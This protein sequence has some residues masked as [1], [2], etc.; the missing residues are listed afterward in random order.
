MSVHYAVQAQVIDLL[1]DTPAA[2]EAF[3]VDTNVWLWTTYA[4]ATQR[5]SP[6]RRQQLTAC[7]GYLQRCQRIG[8]QLHWC[9]L[10]LSE[11]AHQIESAER[12]VWNATER[13]ARRAECN[14]KEFRH[15]FPNERANVVQEIENA[16]RSV[17][18]LATVL[19]AAL[20]VGGPATTQALVEL[21]TC[22]L[23]GYDLFFLQAARA[24]GVTQIISDD[25]DF[26]GVPEITLFTSNR[27]VLDAARAQGNLLVR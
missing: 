12:D 4:N 1:T 14:A 18:A 17:E 20:V 21:K 13:A 22:A 16:W 10:A 11:L 25:G 27:S 23:D 9:G 2:G 19:P 5:V 26:C 15:N 6:Q 24:S 8:A 3:F 7:T